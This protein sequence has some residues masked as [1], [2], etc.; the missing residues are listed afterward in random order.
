MHNFSFLCLLSSPAPARLP[1][2]VET[3]L[4]ALKPTTAFS[5]CFEFSNILETYN[6]FSFCLAFLHSSLLCCPPF[7]SP[8]LCLC[9]I[10]H[11]LAG[12]F[13]SCPASVSGQDN[14]PVTVPQKGKWEMTVQGCLLQRGGVNMLRRQK[15]WA[16]LHSDVIYSG[17][18]DLRELVHKLLLCL[19]S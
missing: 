14:R 2:H 5:T 7:S 16:L 1:L 8:S 18:K 11:Y 9:S 15:C 10:L 6:P 19:H 17:R 4:L 3:P 12:V 13:P